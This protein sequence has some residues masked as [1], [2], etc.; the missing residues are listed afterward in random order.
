MQLESELEAKELELSH[1]RFELVRAREMMA[2]T[3]ESHERFRGRSTLGLLAY[4]TS[5]DLRE[6]PVGKWIK[7]KCSQ[8]GSKIGALKR[9]LWLS[10][11]MGEDSRGRVVSTQSSGLVASL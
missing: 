4:G 7:G 8:V 2:L 10:R 11:E 1:A 6:N 5:R 9:R 3:M